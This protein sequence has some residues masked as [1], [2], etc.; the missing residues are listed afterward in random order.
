MERFQTVRTIGT[1]TYGTVMEAHTKVTRE[2]VAVK[3]MKKQYY[4]WDEALTLRE[5][6]VL[7]KLTHPNV[8]KLKEVIRQHN[9]LF[10]IFEYVEGTVL[11]LIR[12]YQKNRQERTGIPEDLIKSVME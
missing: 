9:D 4:T 2:T 7:R 5:V 11:D 8:V 6:K 3:K 1:G 12:N 10:L